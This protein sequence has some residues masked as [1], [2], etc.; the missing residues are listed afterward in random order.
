MSLRKFRHL[1]AK[2]TQ[3][4]QGAL[5]IWA[6]KSDLV[7]IFGVDLAQNARNG[8]VNLS[9]NSMISVINLAKTFNLVVK[10]SANE[11]KIKQ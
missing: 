4:L 9:K 7:Q 5:K 2:E 10:F 6:H 11:V 8:V 1:G 3:G